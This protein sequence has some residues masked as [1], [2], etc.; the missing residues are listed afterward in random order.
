MAQVTVDPLIGRLVDGRYE[1]VARVARGG[2]A[3][4]YRAHDGRLNREIALKVMHP[5]LAEGEQAASFRQRFEREARSAAGLQHHGVVAVYD[6]GTD[7]DMRYLTMEYVP[8]TNLRQLIRD[9]SLTLRRSFAV[10]D[11]VLSALAAAHAKGIVHRDIK[12]EN[13]LLEEGTGRPKVADFGLARA[14]SEVS[15]T[16][17]GTVLGT[18]AYLAP[19]TI[20]T[21]H[22]DMR[23]D[24]YAV[25]ILAFE[26]F[27]GR[28][29]H[30]G[31]GPIQVAYAH[32]NSDVPP[33]S[34]FAGHLGRPLD[35]LV[36]ALT[37][38]DP[39]RRP[40]DAA[41]ALDALRNTFQQIP[42]E[43]LDIPASAAPPPSATAVKAVRT[44]VVE[45][46]AAGRW[47]AHPQPY[48]QA[49][50]PL[51]P[52]AKPRRGGKVLLAL[53]LVAVLLGAW[54]YTESGPGAYAVV[55]DGVVG[56]TA[57]AAEEALTEAGLKPSSTEQHD[58]EVPE[59]EV[60]S[61]VPDEGQRW[62]R[63]QQVRLVV[64]LGQEL[65]EVPAGL[66]GMRE[67]EAR[68]ALQGVGLSD[69]EVSREYTNDGPRDEVIWASV[70]DGDMVPTDEQVRLTVSDGP[71]PV[72]VPDVTGQEVA[73]ATDTL[74]ADGF[75]VAREDVFDEETPAGTVIRT[76]PGGGK[77]AEEGGTVTV[78]VSM[79]P[80]GTVPDVAGMSVADA[81]EVLEKAGYKVQVRGFGELFGE[82]VLET[83][84]VA[85]E[86]LKQGGKVT[87]WTL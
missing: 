62:R 10:L 84:P 4:V 78:F 24:V 17:T 22:V 82:G 15:N 85:G 39:D 48:P 50:P 71:P 11:V 29:P 58:S 6:Q 79:G 65:A 33:V 3:T 32:V 27:T 16:T 60:I 80:E 76:D 46:P 21:G 19:E 83:E 64:S 56:V 13:V 36:R 9:G 25:G 63:D 35:L 67:P 87:I 70:R 86:Q 54:W 14:V 20:S 59:G 75:D 72:T 34:A 18:V 28:L 52:A 68:D 51:P 2:M 8:G 74:S 81:Q 38:R 12:P 40:R 31:E 26:L 23:A 73:D 30:E 57:Q 55:P 77:G 44:A 5:H 42:N 43:V 1:I 45:R 7:G 53:A 41:V 49:Q 47:A 69:V 61:V 66:V 37:A